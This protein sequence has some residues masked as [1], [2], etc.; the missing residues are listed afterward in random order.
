MA[1]T[2]KPA[3]A[4]KAPGRNGFRYR[5]QY[6][7]IVICADEHHQALMYEQLHGQGFKLKVVAV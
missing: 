4:G 6:G 2:K 5:E 7:V 1:T 3:P